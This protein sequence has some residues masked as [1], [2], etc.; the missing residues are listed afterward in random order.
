MLASLIGAFVS[1]EALDAVQRAKAAAI[2]YVLAGLFFLTGVGFVVGAGYIAAAREF[3]SITAAVAFGVGFLLLAAII[4][5]VRSILSST[6]R[7]RNRQRGVDLATI[8]GVAAVTGLPLLVKRGGVVALLAPVA[9][10]AAY[11]IYRETRKK[12]GEEDLDRRDE[13]LM[14]ASRRRRGA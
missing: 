11:A 9:A 13:E 14:A 8:A 6:R 12:W 3:G 1:G 10:L 7:R 2:A 4:L 5:A